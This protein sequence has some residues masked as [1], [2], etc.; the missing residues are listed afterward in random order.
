M[1]NKK[2]TQRL[3]ESLPAHTTPVF[4]P[5]SAFPKRLS[6]ASCEGPIRSEDEKAENI[7]FLSG[8]QDGGS[9]LSTAPWPGM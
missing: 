5:L 6:H 1:E 4:S 7:N 8:S 2:Q 9:L 3:G